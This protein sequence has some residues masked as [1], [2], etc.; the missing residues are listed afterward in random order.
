MNRLLKNTGIALGLISIAFFVFDF[1]LF[2]RLRPLMVAYK[3]MSPSEEHLLNW[4]GIGL[5]FFLAFYLLSLLRLAKYIRKAR[6]ITFSPLFLLACGVLSFL[7]VF[8]DFALLSD[9][10]KQYKLNLSQPEWL[11]LYPIMGFQLIIAVVFTYIHLFSFKKKGQLAHI[12]RDNN[13]FLVT[14]YVGLICS[15]MGLVFSSLGFL[16][17]G[18]W[19]L[20]MHVTIT[21]IVLLTP[22]ALAV[23]YWV[24]T[25]LQEEKRMWYDEKQFQDIGKSAFLTLIL[26]AIF[27]ILLFI[28]NYHNLAGVVSIAW[29]PLYLF[30]TLFI[31]SLSNLFFSNRY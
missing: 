15:S 2:S 21:L 24:L 30:S 8:S 18:G 17:P 13:I 25:K 4:V 28:V 11:I 19:N 5:L 31:F 6:K 14:Q 1:S 16:F 3:P 9:I 7:F 22:Y 26:S 27:M 12:V 20:D 29:L 10:V 23:G